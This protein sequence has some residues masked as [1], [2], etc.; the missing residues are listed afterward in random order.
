MAYNKFRWWTNGKRKTLSVKSH[1]WD[2]IQN[3]DFE[4]SHYYTEEKA[5]RKQSSDLYNEIM[6]KCPDGGDYW[7]YEY[8]ARQKTYLKNVRAN[9]LAE[10][11]HRDDIKILNNFKKELEKHFGF[12]LWNKLM[13]EK[14]MSTEDVYEYYCIEK[15]FRNGLDVK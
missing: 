11:G 12:C 13:D 14:P 15:M 7:G 2:R 3:G 5:A 1:L 6:S 10:E 8:E 9:K 4:Y